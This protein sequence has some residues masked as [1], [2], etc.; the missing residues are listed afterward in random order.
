MTD[1]S[2]HPQAYKRRS[3][4]YRKLLGMNPSYIEI[5]DGVMVLSTDDIGTQGQDRHQ[6]TLCDLSLIPRTGFKGLGTCHW[7]AQQGLNIPDSVNCA[8]V[9]QDGCLV[10][11][12]GMEEVLLMDSI[13]SDNP[14]VNTLEKT[15]LAQQ[16][17]ESEPMGY[18]LP[19]QDSHACF[20]L[21]GEKVSDM[22]AKLCAVDLRPQKFSNLSIAQTSIARIASIVIRND[23]SGTC[24]Y[25][26]STDSTPAG[27]LWDCLIDTMQ[28][29]DGQIVGCS[30]FDCLTT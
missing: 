25:L 9:S 30:N 3:F 10:T 18:P 4:V 11:R 12:L 2:I 15:W 13:K 28:E 17:N 22:L 23:L 16:G 20:G 1:N 29:F 14:V 24:R 26:L 7:L 19:R 5:N 6:L 27:W 21:T 8:G